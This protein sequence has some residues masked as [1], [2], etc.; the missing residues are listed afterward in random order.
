MRSI[1]LAALLISTSAHADSFVEFDGALAIP[2]SNNT[3]TNA[4]DTSLSLGG[5]IG[6][7]GQV[8]GLFMFDWSPMSSNV[9]L[10]DLN[11]FRIQGGVYIE[12]HIAPKVLL[13]GRFT[14]GVDILHSHTELVVL[15]QTFSGSDTDAG[16]ALE[17][18][19]G[20]W[21]ELSTVKLGVELALPISYHNK[22]GNAQNPANDARFDYT[23]IDLNV[24]GGVRLAF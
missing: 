21:Y 11:R 4:V 16:L 22:K 6:G 23:S 10:T 12:N 2:M 20:A 17:P 5:R 19:V 8:G 18:A 1:A 13:R 3:W 14:A 15:G 24:S 7:G 9:A